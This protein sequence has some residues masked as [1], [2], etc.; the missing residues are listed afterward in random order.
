MNRWLEDR[1]AH[2]HQL[3]QRAERTRSREDIL[4]WERF[5][6]QTARMQ[7]TA[8]HLRSALPQNFAVVNGVRA[9]FQGREIYLEH[10]VVGP[11][12]IYLIESVE[13][14]PLWREDL[15][16]S[17]AF[18]I[19]TLG[20]ESGRFSCLVIARELGGIDHL[21]PG[22]HLVD[23]TDAAIMVIRDTHVGDPLPPAVAQEFWHVLR[24][25]S[26]H[27]PIRAAAEP[28]RFTWREWV[29]IGC[30]FGVSLLLLTEP[31]L[32]PTAFVGGLFIIVAPAAGLAALTLLF[33][34]GAPRKVASW[35]LM[36]LSLM[37]F[38]L[39]TIGALAP[40]A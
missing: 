3:H 22:A 7:V 39:M 10:V 15:A 8:Q 23:S 9:V 21:P 6:R 29:T 5:A 24:A 1:Q 16:R 35:V 34:A 12:G 11:T 36:V 20:S 2:A 31:E 27:G 30:A 4:A 14:N 19:Q 26:A 32:G 28:R 37:F 25:L 13:D 33:P 40:E 18:F 38:L 17:I